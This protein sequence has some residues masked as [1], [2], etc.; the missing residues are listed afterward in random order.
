M[1]MLD[2]PMSGE[3]GVALIPEVDRMNPVKQRAI[4]ETL[5]V[6]RLN[7]KGPRTGARGKPSERTCDHV[8]KLHQQ[9]LVVPASAFGYGRVDQTRVQK[10]GRSGGGI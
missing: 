6:F 5:F 9:M 4:H 2:G 7:H 10:P 1:H 3:R 8:A